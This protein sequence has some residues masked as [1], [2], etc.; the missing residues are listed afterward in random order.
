LRA[1]IHKV[2]ARVIIVSVVAFVAAPHSRS[3]GGSRL[4]STT[5]TPQDH[6]VSLEH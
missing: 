3:S 5:A 6:D 2:L 4:T 1:E